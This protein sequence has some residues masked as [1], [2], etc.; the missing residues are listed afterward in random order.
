LSTD[1]GLWKWRHD[2]P[3]I[4]AGLCYL[5]LAEGFECEEVAPLEVER[6]RQEIDAA[7]PKPSTEVSFAPAGILLNACSS[8][9]MEVIE[10]FQLLAEREGL[11][12][13]DPQDH[14]AV[15][16]ADEQA[17]AQ[18]RMQ[19][20]EE[21]RIA[22]LRAQL[23][24]LR[25]QSSSGDAEAT[26][27]LANLYRLGEAVERDGDLAFQLYER[28][29]LAGSSKAMFHLAHCYRTGE[30]VPRDVAQAVHWYT[31]ASERDPAFAC[32]ALGEIY[33]NGE[34]GAP[35]PDRARQALQQSWEHGNP[36]AYRLLRTLGL[37][38]V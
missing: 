31:R 14:R 15:T 35:D 24:G 32:F 6:L 30:G 21:Q 38:P 18:R 5:M 16:K 4:T 27:T 17:F 37:K 25:R 7:F 11:V 33:A 34:L 10:W 20:D 12:F 1:Y 22:R 19:Y 29:A 13:F 28:A 2:P 9:P 3:R 8:T 23:D 26:F 36:A